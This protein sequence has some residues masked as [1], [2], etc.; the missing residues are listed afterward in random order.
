MK[1]ERDCDNCCGKSVRYRE[2]PMGK[3][4]LGLDRRKHYACIRLLRKKRCLF[5]CRYS[6]YSVVN[7][8]G[9]ADSGHYT[10]FIRQHK[11]HWFRCEDNLITKASIQDV[12]RSEG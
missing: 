11:D 2:K 10:C 8:R 3:T 5:V 4:N 12:L 1:R 9:T 6:L 7:H